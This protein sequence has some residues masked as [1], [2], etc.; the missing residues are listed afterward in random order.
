MRMMRW[1]LA[2]VLLMSSETRASLQQG[3]PQRLFRAHRCTLPQELLPGV[4][5]AASR[6]HVVRSGESRRTWPSSLSCADKISHNAPN[7]D[8]TGSLSLR[9]TLQALKYHRSMASEPGPKEHCR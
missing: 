7:D 3:R 9:G 4:H 8:C 1:D 6:R 5:C 2:S